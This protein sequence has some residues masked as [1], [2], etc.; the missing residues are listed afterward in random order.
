MTFVAST[1]SDDVV[2]LV[3]SVAILQKEIYVVVFLWGVTQI[4]FICNCAT[5]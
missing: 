4:L 1:F 2:L 5:A 3:C